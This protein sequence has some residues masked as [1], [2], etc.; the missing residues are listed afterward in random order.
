M[1]QKQREDYQRT[2]SKWN[3]IFSAGIPEAPNS[4]DTGYAELN[5]ALDW[6][7][8]DSATI[9]DFGCGN[10]TMLCHCALRG[11]KQLI[12]ID[13]SQNGIE[14]AEIKCRELADK[15]FR[16]FTGSTEVLKELESESQDGIILSNIIDNIYPQDGILLMEEC[17]RVLKQHGKVFVKLNDYI[18][19]EQIIK[20]NMKEIESNV[21]DDGLLLWNQTDEE[22]I[23]FFEK[24]F[25]IEGRDKIYYPKAEQFNRMF[26]LIKKGTNIG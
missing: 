14:Q 23:K 2:K 15:K 16:F 26:R 8:G 24:Y 25:M 7:C 3:E 19:S 11:T 22:W 5:S 4:T 12:G 1:K 13:F 6:L 18:T 10:G 21:Y 20:W 9:L 17:C